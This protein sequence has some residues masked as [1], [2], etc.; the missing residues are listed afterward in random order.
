MPSPFPGM[1]PYIE[2]PELWSDFHSD[3]A[4]EIRARLNSRV[5]PRYFARLTPF[6][7]YEVI[8][9]AQSFGIR[10]DVSVWQT[11]PTRGGLETSVATI[12]PAP[13][14]STVPLEIPLELFTVEIRTAEHQQL[15]TVIEIL[16]PVNKR[17]GHEAHQ[18]YARKRRD[19]LRSAVHFMEIDLLRSGERF[20]LE[21]PV[22]NAPYYVF[23][24]RAD[25]RPNIAVWPI[26]LRD[27]LPVLPVPLL[28]PDPDA[29]LDL[30][31]AVAA[32][33]ER[34]A[35]AVQIDYSKPPPPP[36][37]AEEDVSFDQ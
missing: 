19:L 7:T 37:L 9:V 18:D 33:Y 36:P 6:V 24:S 3:L 5:Q 28:E 22:P 35:Y 30:G 23:L 8:E 15:V 1:D 27:K 32:V 2:T 25:R 21:K 12:T 16:S 11:Q 4:S 26:A 13:V 34:G 29:P 17:P 14:T 20:P 10:P 31:A